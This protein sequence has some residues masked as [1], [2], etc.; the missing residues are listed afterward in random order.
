MTV[1]TGPKVP[2]PCALIEGG[3]IRAAAMPFDA[4]CAALAVTAEACTVDVRTVGLVSR[5]GHNDDARN[6]NRARKATWIVARRFRAVAQ[7]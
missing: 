7:V 4:Y 5:K 6:W 3:E 1:R 2:P